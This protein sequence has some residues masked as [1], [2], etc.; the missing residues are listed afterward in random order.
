MKRKN[1]YLHLFFILGFN[2]L[3]L[4]QEPVEIYMNSENLR[5]NEINPYSTKFEMIHGSNEVFPIEI[6]QAP[7]L[8]TISIV[9]C[10]L[11]SVPKEIGTLKKLWRLNFNSNKLKTIPDEI[12]ALKNLQILTL[13]S[14]LLT[15]LPQDLSN[16]QQLSELDLRGNKLSSF[17][18]SICTL[19]NLRILD[20]SGNSFQDIP[21][22]FENLTR[23][24]ILTLGLE[25]FKQ[26][27]KPV[28]SLRQLE[29]L[30]IWDAK[31]LEL[32]D[33][34][35][36]KGLTNLSFAYSTINTFPQSVLELK[37]MR[38]LGFFKSNLTEI[39]KNIYQLTELETLDLRDNQITKL[40]DEI[41]KLIHLQELK[42]GDNPINVQELSR[43][44][45]LLPDCAIDIF[46][47]NYYSQSYASKGKYD[48]ACLILN[49]KTKKKPSNYNNW[50]N[51]SWYS[52]FIDK[53]KEAIKAAEQVLNLEPKKVDVETNLAL[54]YVLDNQWAKAEEI[55]L[56]WK[57]KNFPNNNNLCDNIFL[58]DIT[59]LEKAGIKHRDFDKVKRLFGY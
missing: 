15:E 35:R 43:I 27:P 52:L 51:L 18:K 17:P 14:N 16:L 12:N 45:E 38:N 7:D 22:E 54:A 47:D 48:I 56:K 26:F 21:D 55:Y 39:P 29:V 19:T 9:H 37:Q 57:G 49:E 1:L 32:D 11:K 23:L 8:Q 34:A 3:L 50:Y 46:G 28:T 13:S 44:R 36:L 42:I 41:K 4:S 2:Q 30:K 31:N 40:P 25:N 10:D 59:D 20:L 24:Q 33:I 58:K 6:F 53:P 5:K